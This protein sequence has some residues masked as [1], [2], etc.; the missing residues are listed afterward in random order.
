MSQ[1]RPST[2]LL[3]L[4][5]LLVGAWLALIVVV[6]AALVL[7]N[8]E[9]IATHADEAA[10][11]GNVLRHRAGVAEGLLG[12]F[13]VLLHMRRGARGFALLLP[14]AAFTLAVVW[15]L[16]V[17]P[18]AAEVATTRVPTWF[19]PADAG[20]SLL[21]ASL[22]FLSFFGELVSRGART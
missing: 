22:L 11:I 6:P 17:V 2:T 21:E 18:L 9:L 10:R 12:A 4:E 16:V 15:A 8:R 14:F 20:R 19:A 3:P 1:R 5:T 13:V 7:V